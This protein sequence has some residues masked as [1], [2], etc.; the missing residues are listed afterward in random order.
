M[1]VLSGCCMIWGGLDIKG[2]FKVSE[3]L[4]KNGGKL[5]ELLDA[6]LLLKALSITE[7]FVIQWLNFAEAKGNPLADQGSEVP[8]LQNNN[9]Q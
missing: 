8:A 7:A 4:I 5:A 9:N 3:Q 6:I 1:A 2:I